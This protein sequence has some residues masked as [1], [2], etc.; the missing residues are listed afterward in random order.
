MTADITP[1]HAPILELGPGTGVLTDAVVARGVPEDAI[2]LIEADPGFADQLAVRFPRARILA[3]DATGLEELPAIFDEPVGA[4][5]SGLPL[6][7]MPRDKVSAILRGVFR[8]L[9]TSGALYQFTYLPRCPVPG[10][11][12]RDLDLESRR[13]SAAWVNL[14]PAFVYRIRLR[15]GQ[16]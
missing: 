1:A 2:A 6:L 3:M 11:V 12:M 15:R 10:V 16:G 8:H 13:V 5:V 4:V 14:P 7:S 9:R